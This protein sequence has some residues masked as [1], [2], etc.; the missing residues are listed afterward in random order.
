MQT[1]TFDFFNYAGIHRSVVLYTTPKVHISDIITTTNIVEQRGRIFYQVITNG[2]DDGTDA[3]LYVT[4]QIRDR[5]GEI[6]A[7][8]KSTQN[9]LRGYIEIENVKPWW[10]YLMHPEPGYLYTMEVCDT[11]LCTISMDSHWI[12]TVTLISF[13]IQVYLSSTSEEN[14]DVYRL[15][16]GVRTLHWNSREFLINGR[17][18]YLRGFGRHEDSD[19]SYCN[20]IRLVL[21]APNTYAMYHIDSW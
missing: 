1:Y 2:T 19:V 12:V 21:H 13:S 16:I 3:E 15:K 11:L 17:P 6:V 9:D 4:V 14:M 18:L 10:P 8:T 20:C 5:D 7:T